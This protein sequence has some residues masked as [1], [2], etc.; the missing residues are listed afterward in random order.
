M[1]KIAGM[2]L[3]IRV[4]FAILCVLGGSRLVAQSDGPFGPTAL[5]ITYKAKPG[6]RLHFLSLMRTEGVPQYDRWKRKGIFSNYQLLEPAYA[7]AGEA[8]PDLY[9]IL[10]FSHFAD[11]AAWEMIE[12]TLPGGL[13]LAAQGIAWADTSGTA[14]VVKGEA[15]APST[16]DSQFFVLTYDVMIPVQAYRKYALGYVIPQFEEWMKASVLNSYAVFTNQNPAGAPWGS[17]ILLEYKN[18][19]A[20]GRREII[21]DQARKTLGAT[22]AEWEK[23]SEDKTNIRKEKTA[24]PVIPL[25]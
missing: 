20:L 21:K 22:N 24:V 16:R 6:E 9:A 7:A 12:K 15:V 17:F 23:W 3:R 1:V 11:L 4:G 14:D 18:M 10:R 13:P 8:T 19:D 5:I 25:L 2:G